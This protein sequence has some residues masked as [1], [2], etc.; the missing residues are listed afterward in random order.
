M[1]TRIHY[2]EDKTTGD[3]NPDPELFMQ[4]MLENI[5]LLTK[6]AI[7]YGDAK[8]ESFMV[9]KLSVMQVQIDSLKND[10]DLAK[11]LEALYELVKSLDLD[12][13]GDIVSNLLKIQQIANEALTASRTN[14]AIL[15]ETVSSFS[16][17]KASTKE[18]LDELRATIA[19][20][21]NA[22]DELADTL[23]AR[24]VD[25]IAFNNQRFVAGISAGL[26]AF[27]DVFAS[28]PPKQP[29]ILP[30]DGDIV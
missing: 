19:T 16:E 25:L 30:V 9:E 29:H 27:K 8:L 14:G 26:Q 18:Q 21:R 20:S 3:W 22:I 12:G 23:Y 13:N 7:D 11:R 28:E 10:P 24:I 17:F 2:N 4:D 6:G 15:N 1:A 5:A